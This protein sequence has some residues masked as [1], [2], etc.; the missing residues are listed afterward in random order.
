MTI[1]GNPNRRPAG[2]YPV[3]AA[4]RRS[5]GRDSVRWRLPPPPPPQQVAL[6]AAP[7]A[8]SAA[9]ATVVRPYGRRR[10]AHAREKALGKKVKHSDTDA[11]L[12]HL[13]FVWLGE[14]YTPRRL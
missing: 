11:T 13:F 5:L 14:K 3:R 1:K 7:A 10:R 8:R 9:R 6:H 2:V 4:L 12:K